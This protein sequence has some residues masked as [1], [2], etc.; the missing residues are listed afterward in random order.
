[1]Y[2]FPTRQVLPIIGLVAFLNERVDISID[3]I[4]QPRPKTHMGG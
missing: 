1:M 4:V 2:S 3:G